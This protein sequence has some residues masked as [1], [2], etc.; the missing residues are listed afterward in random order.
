MWNSPGELDAG[1]K[2]VLFTKNQVSNSLDVLNWQLIFTYFKF[3]SS[4]WKAI[5]LCPLDIVNT[6]PDHKPF[7]F[8]TVT[9]LIASNWMEI[10]RIDRLHLLYAFNLKLWSS[11]FEPTWS[12]SIAKFVNI[13]LFIRTTSLIKLDQRLKRTLSDRSQE[14]A[15][16]GFQISE[17]KK[18]LSLILAVDFRSRFAQIVPSRS[19]IIWWAKRTENNYL[20]FTL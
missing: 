16:I 14:L 17:A 5:R 4:S 11:N 6:G 3:S 13:K 2:S 20:K 15:F 18:E 19:V 12:E 10:F 7:D 8:K 1:S 9:M